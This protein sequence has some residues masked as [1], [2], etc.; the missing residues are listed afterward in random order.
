VN[1]YEVTAM[2]DDERESLLRVYHDLMSLAQ[3]EVPSVRAC[4]RT[5]VAY[6]AQALNGQ[7]LMYDLYTNRW[8]D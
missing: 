3:C 8:D 5:A 7:G 6:V 4:A 2:T 1:A